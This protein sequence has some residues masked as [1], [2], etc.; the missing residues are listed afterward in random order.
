MQKIPKSMARNIGVSN[1][2]N[3]N[4]R[5]LLNSSTCKT[6]PAVNQ[7]EIHPGNPSSRLV[8]FCHG[9]GIHCTAYSCLGSTDSP[10]YKD[11]TLLLIGDKRGKTPQQVLLAW[12][13]QKGWSVIPK[14]VSKDRI[15]VNFGLDGW[16]LTPEE[17]HDIDDVE[18]RFK[19]CRDDWLPVQVFFDDD[20]D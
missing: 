1:F 12:G 19:V 16:E 3:R 8:G 17:I 6:V 14:S 15:E 7:I 4:L 2:G 20:Y 18:A 9:N 11:P 10:L 13:I 5:R